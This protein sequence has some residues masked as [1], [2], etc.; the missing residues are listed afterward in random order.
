VCRATAT[1]NLRIMDAVPSRPILSNP[2]RVRALLGPGVMLLVALVPALRPPGALAIVAGW[3]FLRA[4]HRPE[5]IAWAAVLPLAVILTWLWFLGADVPVGDP[6]CRD[7]LS[8]I[9]MSPST[10]ASPVALRRDGPRAM[11]GRH[12]LGMRTRTPVMGE[13]TI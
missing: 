10:S 3:L 11:P 6:A 2:G 7:P 12:H 9:A 1:A 4:I 13:G 5:A 8:A